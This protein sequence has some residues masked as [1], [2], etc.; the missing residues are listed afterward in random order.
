MTPT[1]RYPALD[2]WP[3]ERKREINNSTPENPVLL[4]AEEE[5]EL[6]EASMNVLR[7]SVGS[8]RLQIQTRPGSPADKALKLKDKGL[9][10]EAI[11]AELNLDSRGV[12]RMLERTYR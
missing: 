1:T 12:K 10:D 3:R 2:T 4:T 6:R 5:A 7:V 11:A 9:S 8:G